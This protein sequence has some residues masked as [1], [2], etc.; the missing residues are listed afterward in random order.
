M[1]SI[2]QAAHTLCIFLLMVVV[3]RLLL[4]LLLPMIG[5]VFSSL[6]LLLLLLLLRCEEVLTDT[7]AFLFMQ[8]DACLPWLSSAVG[9]SE[10]V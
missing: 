8:Q 1:D 6:L 10:G 3:E 4:L 7:P 5:S 2:N 9:R